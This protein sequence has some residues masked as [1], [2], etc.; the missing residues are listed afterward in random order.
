MGRICPVDGEV[1]ET[2]EPIQN[3]PSGTGQITSPG[4]RA[5]LLERMLGTMALLREDG[6]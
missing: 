1:F 2:I 6:F 3:L 4:R 5:R